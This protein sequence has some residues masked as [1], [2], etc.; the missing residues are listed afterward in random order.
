MLEPVLKIFCQRE[1]RRVTALWI[2]LQALQ[3]N[4]GKLAIYLRIQQARFARLGL[5]EQSERFV[6][7][8]CSKRRLVGKQLVKYCAQSVHVCRACKLG[9]FTAS[10]FWCHVTRGAHYSW[11]VREGALR[12]DQSRE[13]EIGQMRFA[14]CV[15]QNVSRFDVAMED[16]VLVRVMDRA[17]YFGDYFCRLP[18]GHWR[19][20]YHF[21][22]LAAF[23]ELH[24]EVAGTIALAHF[25]DG[26]DARVIKTRG[27]CRFAAKALQ[28]RS[29]GPLTK[30]KNF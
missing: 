16:S 26:N 27:G 20:A 24:A 15:E 6:R 30:L 2:F 9:I 29:A 8:L 11:C 14:V 10:L 28:V 22:K 18:H 7:S 3:A 19:T 21:I 5:D 4:R 1:S 13:A 23:D 17:R 25:V 12:F